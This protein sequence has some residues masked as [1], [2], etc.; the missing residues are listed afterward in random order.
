RGTNRL[1]KIESILVDL[2]VPKSFM[3]S[4]TRLIGSAYIVR[5]IAGFGSG[6]IAIPLLALIMP[7]SIA[8]P[9]IVL[10]D[11]VASASH[12][13]SNR[14]AIQWRDLLPLLPFS[15]LGVVLA[16]YLFQSLDTQVLIRGLGIFL[17]LFAVY[18]LFSFT[19]KSQP[20]ILWA[21]PGGIL[22][23]LIGT[24]FGTGGPFY[25]IY[26]K[27][28]G[29]QKNSFR[30]TFAAIFLLDGLGRISG[31]L[32]TGF[33]DLN[34]ILLTALALPLMAVGMYVGG[35]IHTNLS[36]QTFQ[37]GISVLLIFSGLSLLFK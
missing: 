33:F 26:L 25:V 32:I 22:G 15:L 23:G 8:V 28:R 30:A 14:K 6:L 35:Q 18:S 10:L 4:K 36:Q 11:Y 17:L 1:S 21:I 37:R 2:D 9:M 7:L 24:L 27:L 3:R 13:L 16:L 29:L 20:S 5:G 34:Q 31:Y 12:G 19:P